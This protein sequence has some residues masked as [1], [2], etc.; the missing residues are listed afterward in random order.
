MRALQSIQN[1]LPVHTGSSNGSHIA[2]A[3]SM[4]I[5][6][7]HPAPTALNSV[8]TPTEQRGTQKHCAR[9]WPLP[10]ARPAFNAHFRDAPR[11]SRAARAHT[12][13]S[14]ASRVSAASQTTPSSS[15]WLSA[16]QTGLRVNLEHSARDRSTRSPILMVTP[17]PSQLDHHDLIGTGY[18][19]PAG[20]CK[21]S[22]QACGQKRSTVQW[23]NT[24]S[25]A[26]WSAIVSL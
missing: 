7:L 15:W 21:A 11:P 24:F 6:E 4:H 3:Y 19:P 5:T 18:T 8:R 10:L 16:F 14:I 9:L 12:V 1:G 26:L 13:D 22:G 17:C 20:S 25:S 2:A 23:R